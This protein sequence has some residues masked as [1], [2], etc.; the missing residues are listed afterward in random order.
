VL[1]FFNGRFASFP[2]PGWTLSWYEELFADRELL[3]S[4]AR[5]FSVGAFA[6]IIS[7]ILGFPA[8][9]WLSRI[10]PER[11]L[12]ILLLWTAPV[13][14]PFLLFGLSFSQ[15]SQAIGIS[16]TLAAVVLAHVVLFCP[17]VV[18]LTFHRC[19]QLDPNVEAAAR[20]LGASDW[21]LLFGIVWRQVWATVVAGA[22]IV[23]V[24]SWDEYIVAWFL[25]GFEKTY[26]VHVRNMLESTLSPEIHAAG[27]IVAIGSCLVVLVAAQLLRRT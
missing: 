3:L 25:T 4:I 13:F 14:V 24:L 2:W 6:S 8:G 10:R 26:P 19:R 22:A 7:V 27:V 12:G 16:R 1:S 15:L 11:A 21:Q 20:E 17:I 23:F 5:S 18:V 9:Y